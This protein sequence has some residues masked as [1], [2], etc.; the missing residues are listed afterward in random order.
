[1]MTSEEAIKIVN[2]SI[3][4]YDEISSAARIFLCED[5]V[6]MGVEDWIVTP[7]EDLL[8]DMVDHI[9]HSANEG[10]DGAFLSADDNIDKDSMKE[11]C[12]MLTDKMIITYK[13]MAKYASMYMKIKELAGNDQL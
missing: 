11:F 13:S 10:I 7:L 1:M 5:I 9:R 4:D 2:Q 8:L 6:E 12:F 3:G